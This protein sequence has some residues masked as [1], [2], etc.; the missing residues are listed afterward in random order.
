MK[1]KIIFLILGLVLGCLGEHFRPFVVD[2]IVGFDRGLDFNYKLISFGMSLAEVRKLMH[3][4]GTESKEFR[5]GQPGGYEFEYM[6]A[7]K[8][9]ASFFIFW[10]NGVDTF[11]TIGFD[12]K[13]RAIYKA[14]GGT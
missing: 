10:T 13:G 4:E 3:S 8:S 9:G 5:L 14:K 11:Y 7:E 6:A 12:D 1:Y 2:R